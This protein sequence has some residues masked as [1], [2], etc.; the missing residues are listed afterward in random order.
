M[1]LNFENLMYWERAL[2]FVS[3]SLCVFNAYSLI[4]MLNVTCVSEEEEEED[5]EEEYSEYE[6]VSDDEEAWA[7]ES[8][9]SDLDLV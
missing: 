8:D 5:E 3:S 7:S 2:L 9:E 1:F 6:P 4:Y